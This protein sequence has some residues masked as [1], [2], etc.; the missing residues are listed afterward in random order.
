MYINNHKLPKI[1]NM[2]Q[3][4]DNVLILTENQLQITNEKLD[5][6]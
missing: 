3:F 6:G 5:E 4:E 1:C 2:L